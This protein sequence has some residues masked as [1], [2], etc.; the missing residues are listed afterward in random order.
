M[1]CRKCIAAI[2]KVMRQCKELAYSYAVLLVNLMGSL[3]VFRAAFDGDESLEEQ[4]A[5]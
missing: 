2:Q 1:D 5:M 4:H 3:A